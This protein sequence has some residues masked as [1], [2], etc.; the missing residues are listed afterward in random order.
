VI[1]EIKNWFLNRNIKNLQTKRVRSS[2]ES[3]TLKRMQDYAD[4]GHW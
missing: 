4:K 2:Q 1:K 3:E